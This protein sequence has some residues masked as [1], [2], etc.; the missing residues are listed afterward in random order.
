MRVTR[1]QAAR[2]RERVVQAASAL[3]R[4]RGLEGVGVAEL[5][6]AAGLTHGGF[7]GQFGSKEALLAEA[8]AH[9]FEVS[10]AHWAQAA[11]RTPDE[12]LS[13][14]V[15]SYLSRTH[16]E[17]AAEGCAIPSLGAE[18]ARHGAGPHMALSAG[19][20]GLI[21]RLSGWTRGRDAAARRERAIGTLAALVGGLVLARAVDEAALSDEILRATRQQLLKR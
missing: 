8:I 6:N 18:A 1:E 14:V 10:G 11:A 4:E 17:H 20:R 3:L 5:M 21:E 9:A 7:Y 16:R 19:V 15:K 2:N 13:G 12:P